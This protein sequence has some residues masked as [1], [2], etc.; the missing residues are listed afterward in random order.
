MKATG[1]RQGM[2]FTQCHGLGLFGDAGI[3]GKFL[4]VKPLRYW[5]CHSSRN[6]LGVFRDYMKP[7]K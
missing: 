1:P 3:L 2:L 4:G 5:L 7:F 6:A